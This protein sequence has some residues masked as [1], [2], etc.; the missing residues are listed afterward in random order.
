M[1][2]SMLTV[3]KCL[4]TGNYS[5]QEQKLDIKF[6]RQEILGINKMI[7][8]PFGERLLLYADYTASGRALGFIEH[9]LNRI[10]TLYANS[11]TEDDTSGRLTTELLR[12]AEQT[13]KSA[14]NA[15]EQGRLIACGAGATGA[16]DKVQQIIGVGIPSATLA[17]LY[18]LMGAALGEPQRARFQSYLETHQ[19]VVFV[20]PY[21]HHSN[22]ISWRESL[23]TVVE[24]QADTEGG[25]DLQHL[26]ALLQEPAYQGRQR[27]GSFSA[28]SNVTGMISPVYEIARL[29]HQHDALAFFDYA[30]SAPYVEIDMN[31]ANQGEGAWLDAIFVSPHK[32]L[33]GPG[34]SGLL[35]FNRRIYHDELAPSVAGGGT[36]EYV[37][38]HSHDFIS[39]IETREKA[40]TPGILQTLRAALVFELKD[41]LGVARIEQ[42]EQELTRRAMSQWDQHAN[43]EVLGNPDPARRIGIISFNIKDA[44]GRYLHPRFVTVLLDNL[45]GI[46][47]RGGCS[48]AGPYGH[49]LLGIG[50]DKAEAYRSW[51]HQGYQGIKPGWCR[52]GMHYVFDD[53]EAQYLVDTVLFVAEYGE[54]FL[55]LYEFDPLAGTWLMKQPSPQYQ[56]LPVTLSLHEAFETKQHDVV[57]SDNERHRL[58]SQQLDS[59][60]KLA[61]DLCTVAD[62]CGKL[63]AELEQ[64]R[65]FRLPE[66]SMNRLFGQ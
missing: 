18:Q 26:Q 61:E 54:R 62:E 43:I 9:Y 56:R 45:F 2:L 12:Q 32:F 38:Q 27:I 8:T 33:G 5:M 63:Q 14:V 22:E 29:L 58:Y 28:A 31:P 57:L 24:V 13:I 46:Q 44:K 47:S 64:L 41:S 65:F 19:P 66:E 21:E 15:G 23:A 6:L 36:V 51:V 55:P 48:C 25:I 50:N 20:G 59:A 52:I 34:S 17:L 60:L 40:G 39:D 7:H 1:Q 53:E 49:R 30:A 11:H 3:N 16:I 10:K 37:G 35:V 4:V 42:R